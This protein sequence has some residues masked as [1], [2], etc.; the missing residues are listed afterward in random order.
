ML[1]SPGVEALRF[2]GRQPAIAALLGRFTAPFWQPLIGALRGR[3]KD[4]RVRVSSSGFR[5]DS[6]NRIPCSV[7]EIDC[8]F[9]YI[10]ESSNYPKP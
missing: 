1:P 6:K 7:A 5:G 3:R 2:S 10:I 4:F 8:D 9:R